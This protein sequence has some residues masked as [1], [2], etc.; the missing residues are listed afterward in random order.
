MNE[1]GERDKI[2]IR[3]SEKI[4]Y[5]HMGGG[6][7]LHTPTQGGGREKFA[8]TPH[9]GGRNLHTP[10]WGKGEI[11]IHPHGGREKFAYTHGGGGRNLHTP[12]WGEGEIFAYTH[13]GGGRNFC[14]HKQEGV[15]IYI[16]VPHCASDVCSQK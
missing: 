2:H 4:A 15:V 14:I 3:G 7:N 6:E 16:H 9:G 12:T 5:T 10:T 11:C 8:Y 1:R 13:M